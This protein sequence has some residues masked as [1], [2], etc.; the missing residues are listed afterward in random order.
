[1]HVNPLDEEL[2]DPRLLGG[3]QLGPDRGEVG[4]QYGDLELNPL[5]R[6][7]ELVAVAQVVSKDMPAPK[8]AGARCDAF[9]LKRAAGPSSS[10]T[11]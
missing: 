5:L 8:S 4:E 1:M 7:R 9:R 3:E 11:A 2:D 6:N 10:T